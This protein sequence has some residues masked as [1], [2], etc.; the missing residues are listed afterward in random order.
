MVNPYKITFHSRSWN[1]FRRGW[2]W[3]S[4]RNDKF[5]SFGFITRVHLSYSEYPEKQQCDAF[6]DTKIYN[7]FRGKRCIRCDAI[8]I[9]IIKFT[10][11]RRTEEMEI[12]RNKNNFIP[13]ISPVTFIPDVV[14]LFDCRIWFYINFKL[15]IINRI[16]NKILSI[17]RISVCIFPLEVI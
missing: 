9:H 11:F 17:Q 8:H 10:N 1:E 15:K 16:G 14:D 6:F 4:Q 13:V 7:A 12:I 2:E 5:C 3:E